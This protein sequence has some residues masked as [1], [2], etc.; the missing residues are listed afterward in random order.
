MNAPSLDPIGALAGAAVSVKDA[1]R[2][3]RHALREGRRRLA[4]PLPPDAPFAP[5]ATLAA[6]GVDAAVAGCLD[7]AAR[8]ARA[9]RDHAPLAPPRVAMPA[10]LAEIAA[11]AAGGERGRMALAE[12]GY[13]ALRIILAR[14]GEEDA[15][16]LEHPLRD[17]FDAARSD[18]GHDAQAAAALA[19]AL[20]RAG[21]APQSAVGA[22]AGAALALAAL[23]VSRAG[24]APQ[25]GRALLEAA[26]DMA[27]AVA[28]E[29]AAALDAPAPDD[30]A[31]MAALMSAYADHL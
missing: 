6:R 17:A 18:A 20:A 8:A 11:L 2:V 19:L 1:L 14:L 23:A 13:A 21:A 30:R 27:A 10:P 4:P 26:A 9:A 29:I 28:D 3:A 15:L 31:R 5:V 25:E 16:V 12:G 22:Q 24:P 7:A